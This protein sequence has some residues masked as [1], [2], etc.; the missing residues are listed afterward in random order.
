[1]TIGDGGPED[2]ANVSQFMYKGSQCQQKAWWGPHVVRSPHVDFKMLSGDM[3]I[4]EV[5]KCHR[6][7]LASLL[8]HGHGWTSW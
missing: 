4:V 3:Y 6:A 7:G 2:R 5:R 1:M 8:Q